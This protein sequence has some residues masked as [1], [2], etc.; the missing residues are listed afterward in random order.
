MEHSLRR[1]TELPFVID[2]LQTKQLVLLDPSTWDDKNDS[3]FIKQY[4]KEKNAL[5]TAALCLTECHETYHHWSIFSNGTSGVCIEFNKEK[6]NNNIVGIEN[7]KAKRVDY[8]AIN[9]LKTCPP[10]VD[11]LPFLKRYAFNAENE[12]R[13]F[14]ES[15]EPNHSIFKVSMPLSAIERIILSPWLPPSVAEH[16]KCTLKSISGCS[17]I[18]IHR[19]TLV[20]NEDWKK[21]SHI[22]A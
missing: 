14:W 17:D 18:R 7:L 21:L 3:Y 10:T 12:F 8:K 11:D 9:I 13:L 2:Y 20:E 15:E 4:A 16:V 6:F 1:Y 22:N 19:S 5:S